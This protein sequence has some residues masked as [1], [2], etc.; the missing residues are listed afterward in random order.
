MCIYIT[1]YPRTTKTNPISFDNGLNT[2]FI[3]FQNIKINLIFK[4]IFGFFSFQFLKSNYV[5][6][7]NVDISFSH[8]K[9]LKLQAL[10]A[11]IFQLLI[12]FLCQFLTALRFFI[13]KSLYLFLSNYVAQKMFRKPKTY[14][15][16]NRILAKNI[17]NTLG[18]KFTHA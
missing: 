15:K 12:Q 11:F 8:K 14:Q 1:F 16:L 9:G 3:Y 13:T 7:K 18:V 17:V 6:C 5:A 4:Y 10:Q 2:W